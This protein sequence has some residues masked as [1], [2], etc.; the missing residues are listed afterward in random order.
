MTFQSLKKKSSESIVFMIQL[1]NLAGKAQFGADNKGFW[2]THI[3][4][5][6]P[7][8]EQGFFSVWWC[9]ILQ[10]NTVGRRRLKRL[11]KAASVLEPK[12]FSPLKLHYS[13]FVMHSVHAKAVKKIPLSQHEELWGKSKVVSRVGLDKRGLL[14]S[15]FLLKPS[16]P[17]FFF[18]FLVQ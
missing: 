11:Q 13:V 4:C 18:F 16:G 6:T 14:L 12:D 5:A 17:F 8:T 2:W 10:R 1:S 9:R 15:E 7:W 3:P